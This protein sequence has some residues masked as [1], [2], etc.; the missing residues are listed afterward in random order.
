VSG[1]RFE[2]QGR[3]A[4]I[5]VDRPEQRNA[6]DRPAAEALA[7]AL[8]ELDA[9]DELT[10]GVLTGV[11]P[12]F[13]AGMDLKAL[14]ATGERPHTQTR[15]MF[16]IAERP[17]RKP[18]IAAV[19]GPA[20]GGGLEIALA[21]DLI[22]A[23]ATASFGLPEVRRGL[24]AS[25]GGLVRLPR[26]IPAAAAV[27]LILTGDPISATRGYEL[28]L[29]NAISEPGQALHAALELAARIGQNAPLALLTAKQIVNET[30]AMSVSEALAH[31][32]SLVQAVR[33][34]HDAREGTQAFVEKRDPVWQG[35]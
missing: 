11:G 17:P 22:V 34:S 7:A 32:A 16:G 23:S 3:I 35:R 19:E 6:I 28:G 29:V 21:C 1:I 2:A 4:L 8:D 24:V 31:Q 30:L 10:V 18:L 20:L 12:S 13:S 25:A 9:R 26:R 33:D 15:G 27:E 5:T 14:S